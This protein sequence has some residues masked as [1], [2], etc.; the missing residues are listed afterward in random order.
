MDNADCPAESCRE[1]GRQQ[2]NGPTAINADM[3]LWCDE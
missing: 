1:Q 3:V 2:E